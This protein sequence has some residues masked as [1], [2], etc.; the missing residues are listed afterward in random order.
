MAMV[1]VGLSLVHPSILRLSDAIKLLISS[2]EGISATASYTQ[3][4]ASRKIMKLSGGM[5]VQNVYDNTK[6]ASLWVF[7]ETVLLTKVWALP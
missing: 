3:L 4:K 1:G 5:A 6:D 7:I 2:Q